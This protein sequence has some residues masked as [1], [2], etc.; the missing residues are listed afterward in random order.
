M[1]ASE[2]ENIQRPELRE[3]MA[4]SGAPVSDGVSTGDEAA[5]SGNGPADGAASSGNAQGVAASAG[6]GPVD[7]VASS[8]NGPVDEAASGGNGPARV[9]PFGAQP[10]TFDRVARIFFQLLIAAGVIWLLVILQS[11][12]IP[13]CAACLIAYLIEPLVRWNARWTHCRVRVVSVLLAII[14]VG[15]V[16]AG[17]L[18]L[19][20]PDMI[21][22][23]HRMGKLV[24]QYA[25]GATVSIPLF[26]DGM[27]HFLRANIDLH[28]VA[29][30]LSEADIQKTLS[31]FA[32]FFSGGLNILGSL[33]AW[34]IVILYVFFILL[35]YDSLMSGIKS[36]VPPRYRSFSGPLF[37]DVSYIMRRYFRTQALISLIVGVIYAAG[38]SI[39]G[40]P[41]GVAIGLMNAILFMVPY[42]VYLSLIPVTMLCIITSMETGADFWPLFGKCICVYVVAECI[43]DLVLTPRI[44]GKSLN[45]DPAVILLSLSVWATL[46]GF[47][48]MII[49]L[50]MT[51]LCISYYRVYVLKDSS[52]AIKYKGKPPERTP[53]GR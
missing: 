43:A 13:F 46:L 15:A 25:D 4:A 10:F 6:N 5:S 18:W 26:Q 16:V 38:F 1:S 52:G 31:S 2:H 51:T 44:M 37:A 36:I 48:G 27:H 39:V 53:G 3:D 41:L 49:A 33:L 8:G 11:V 50:P 30:Y 24:K 19:F 35:N 23:A 34:G 28:T 29:R 12:L 9:R 17:F 32:N 20:M 14:K 45:L 40:L 47:M 42:L 7:E 21:V 22:D